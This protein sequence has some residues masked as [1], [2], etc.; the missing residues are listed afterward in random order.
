[1]QQAREAL[2]VDVSDFFALAREGMAGAR[3]AVLE[4]DVVPSLKAHDTLGL[5]KCISA[6]T[7]A[8]TFL[9]QGFGHCEC[10]PLGGIPGS[11][12]SIRTRRRT[13]FLSFAHVGLAPTL[14]KCRPRP[15]SRLL[16]GTCSRRTSMAKFIG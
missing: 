13:G 11:S 9:V 7:A 5:C 6:I 4:T 16:W 15:R 12:A 10:P 8:L 3:L 14:Q 1:M 2:A